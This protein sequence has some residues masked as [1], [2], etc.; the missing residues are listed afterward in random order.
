MNK[1]SVTAAAAIHSFFSSLSKLIIWLVCKSTHVWLDFGPDKFTEI[2][3]FRTI[4][5]NWSDGRG[6]SPFTSSEESRDG[7]SIF[8]SRA[9]AVTALDRRMRLTGDMVTLWATSAGV[10]V[11][12]GNPCK[13]IYKMLDHCHMMITRS[14]SGS[15]VMKLCSC[16]VRAA[17]TKRVLTTHRKKEP[18][19]PFY[20]HHSKCWLS[21]AGGDQD[22]IRRI[23]SLMSPEQLNPD[24]CSWPCFIASLH[25]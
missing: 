16:S 7:S 21:V 24:V 3:I 1:N 11:W 10:S 17:Q 20:P 22:V 4:K 2:K 19:W 6:E 8:E 5:F 9:P 13:L 12:L 18:T 15:P 14:E 25:S 23:V